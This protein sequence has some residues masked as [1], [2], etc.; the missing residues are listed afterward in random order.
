MSRT[1]HALASRHVIMEHFNISCTYQYYIILDTHRAFLSNHALKHLSSTYISKLPC[2][3]HVHIMFPD[4]IIRLSNE[5]LH[6][7]IHRI[8]HLWYAQILH[9]SNI[10]NLWHMKVFTQLY[11]FFL[12][13]A[14]VVSY[15]VRGWRHTKLFLYCSKLRSLSH[16]FF[17][18]KR[19]K[20]SRATTWDL[21]P[22][23]L[24]DTCV[25]WLPDIVS[26]M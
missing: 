14:Y 5:P 2:T 25:Q 13:C 23:F 9:S 21:F 19:W 10:C 18:I 20:T 15:Y 11:I 24:S 12:S 1:Y 8:I 6:A 16:D 26:H 17:S 3:Y 4:C 7:P 22:A